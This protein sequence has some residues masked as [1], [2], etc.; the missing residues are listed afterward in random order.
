MQAS[1]KTL[2]NYMWPVVAH[3]ARHFPQKNY[4]FQDDNAPVRWARTVVKYKP[5]IKIKTLTWAAHIIEN[6]WQR[7]R[8]ELQNNAK[9]HYL[10]FDDEGIR[11]LRVYPYQRVNPTRRVTR[12]SGRVGSG[13]IFYG[14]GYTR[15]YPW[16][17][18]LSLSVVSIALRI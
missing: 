7:L 14:Y 10:W 4:I 8:R 12:G 17:S 3:R 13:K 15:F 16:V 18:M 11:G 2:E 1:T 6:V 9:K 5:K